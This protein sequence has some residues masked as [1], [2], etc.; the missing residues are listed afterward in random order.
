MFPETAG[1]QSCLHEFQFFG[2]EDSVAWLFQDPPSA[3]PPQVTANE[4]QPHVMPVSRYLDELRMPI[5]QGH[6]LTFDVS[7]GRNSTSPADSVPSRSINGVVFTQTTA[8]SA[9]IVSG[10]ESFDL[11]VSPF[12]FKSPLSLSLSTTQINPY[13]TIGFQFN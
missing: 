7:L 10:S 2:N 1:E 8:S 13:L 9:P 3:Q 11:S 12:F 6:G 5:N 4:D